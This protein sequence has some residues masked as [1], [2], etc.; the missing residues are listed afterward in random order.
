[1]SD[2]ELDDHFLDLEGKKGVLRRGL[3]QAKSTGE[4]RFMYYGLIS[5]VAVIK[6]YDWHLL[7]EDGWSL[8][9]SQ[10]ENYSYIGYVKSQMRHGRGTVT[11]AD[12]STYTGDWCKDMRHGGGKLTADDGTATEG[13]FID[14][15]YRSDGVLVDLSIFS[16]DEVLLE[17][18]KVP[19]RKYDST[20]SHIL[21]IGGMLDWRD[22]DE[23]TLE[24]VSKTNAF[25]PLVFNVKGQMLKAG[26]DEG[27]YAQSW[28]LTQGTLLLKARRI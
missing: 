7:N 23:F 12:G 4:S 18:Y 28:P 20:T 9:S 21:R 6:E 15:V 3:N 1:M 11:Y 8:M 16:K 17:S 10:V 22:K 14:N 27:Q 26:S 2:P 24:V 5:E 19:L 13:I 25:Q